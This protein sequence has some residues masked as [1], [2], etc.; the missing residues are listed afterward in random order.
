M[1]WV[2]LTKFLFVNDRRVNFDQSL[3][4]LERKRCKTCQISCRYKINTLAKDKMPRI[5]SFGSKG[6]HTPLKSS[7]FTMDVVTE[8]LLSAKPLIETKKYWYISLSKCIWRQNKCF[9]EELKHQRKQYW[10]ER[11]AQRENP[12]CPENRRKVTFYFFIAKRPNP[13]IDQLL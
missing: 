4:K 2:P 9:R 13:K 3:P 10:I 5:R 12:V 1:L 11:C 7:V 8:N 6:A